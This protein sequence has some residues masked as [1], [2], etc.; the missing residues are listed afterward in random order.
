M[1]LLLDTNSLLWQLGLSQPGRLGSKAKKYMLQAEVVYI[2]AI[3]LVEIQIK[4]MIGKLDA[5]QNCTKMVTD[6]GNQLLP[7]TP[8]SADAIRNY[9]N[10]KRHDPF[11]RMLLAQA[12]NEGLTFL[13]ADLK[14]LE[15]KLPFVISARE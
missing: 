14:L 11:D 7:F 9:P 5:P 12:A 8:D 1:K 13:T 2:S 3:S 15:L 6:A 10:L 4:T